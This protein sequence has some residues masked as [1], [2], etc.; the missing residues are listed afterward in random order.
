MKKKIMMMLSVLMILGIT[1]LFP[2][3]VVHADA[4][5]REAAVKWAYEQEGKFLDYDKAWGAQC[6]DLI[7][8]YY[9]YFGKA[10]YAKGNGCKYVSNKLPDGWTRIKNTASFVPEPGD[11]AVWGTELS[12]DGHVA[13]ILSANAHSFVSMDQNWPSGSPCKQVTHSYNK[14]WG[15]IRPDFKKSESNPSYKNFS[16]SKNE[17]KLKDKI[18]FFITPINTTGIGISI[19]KEGVGRVVAAGCNR[20]NGHDIWASDLGVGN[21]SAHITVYNGNKWADTETVWFSVVDPQPSYSNFSVSQSVYNLHDKI[22]FKIDPINAT[23]FG[24]SIDKEGVGRVVAEG[25]NEANGHS[26]WG[27]GLGVG[28]YSA[29]ITVYNDEKWI[30]TNTVYFSVVPPSYSNLE[31]NKQKVG[32]AEDVKFKINTSHAEFMVLKIENEKGEEVYSERCGDSLDSW[33]VKADKLGVGQ[34]KA[35]FLV[36]STNDYYI[37]TEKIPFTV[38]QSPERSKLTCLP[39]NSYSKTIFQW[40]ET[41]YTD[42][43]DLRIDAADYEKGGNIKNVW[44]LRENRCSV[45]LPAGEYAAHVD[46]VNK[47][48]AVGGELIYFTVKEG[49]AGTPVNLGSEVRA[50]I[51]TSSGRPIMNDEKKVKLDRE[52]KENP[53]QIWKF[54]QQSN[55]SYVVYSEMGNGVLTSQNSVGSSV[56]IDQYQNLD[57]QK[58]NLYGNSED[59]YVLKSLGTGYVLGLSGED[60]VFGN[61]VLKYSDDQMFEIEK[62]SEIMIDTP[63]VSVENLNGETD[64]NIKVKWNTCDNATNYDLLLYDADSKELK[65]KISDIEGTSYIL[66]LAVGNYYV[67]IQAKNE[68]TGGKATSEQVEFAVKE[69]I[70]TCNMILEKS[71]FEYDGTE[72]KPQVRVYNTQGNLLQSSE[73]SV[74]YENNLNAGTATVRI[75]GKNMYLG[76]KTINFA[77]NKAS[78][79]LRSSIDGKR[80]PDGKKVNLGITGIGNIS[81]EVEQKDI[82]EVDADGMVTAKTAGNVDVLVTAEGDKNHSQAQITV[83]FIFEHQYDTGVVTK[84]VS[85]EVDG[86]R[87]YTCSGCKASYTEKIKATGHTW[88]EGKITAE[89][90]CTQKGIRTYTCTVCNTTK[91]EEI[92]ATGHQHTELRNAKPA[93]TDTEGYTGDTYCTDC[94]QLI[95]KGTS[96]PKIPVDENAPTITISNSKAMAG[97]EV[98]VNVDILKNTGIAGYSYDINYDQTAMTLKS[99]SAGKLLAGNGQISTNKN[100]VNWYTADNVTGDGTLMQLTFTVNKD[101]EAGNYPVS[102]A[103]HD[104]K[105][106]LVDEKGTFINANYIAGQIEVTKGMTGDLNGDEDITI[107]DVVLLN[108]H[109]LGKETLTNEQQMLADLN[110]DGDITIADVVIL[111]RVVLGKESLLSEAAALSAGTMETETLEAAAQ[112]KTEEMQISVENATVEPGSTVDIP[113]YLRG[114]TGLAGFALTVNIPEGYRLNSIKPG[115]ILSGG[116]FSAYGNNCTWYTGDNISTNGL[117]LTLNVT[118]SGNAKSGQIAVTVKDGKASNL[119]DERGNAV[120]AKFTAGTVS[121]DSRSECDK[122]GHKGGTAT[123]ISKAVCEVCGQEYGE[124]DLNNH[125]GKT[126]IRNKKAA[127]CTEKG[128]SGDEYC[129]GCNAELSKGTEIA[130]LGHNYGDWTVVKPA[131]ATETGLEERV[132]IR[133]NTHKET[134]EIPKEKISLE[135]CSIQL[136]ETAY[137]YDGTEKKPGVTVVYDGT[138]LTEGTDYVLIYKNNTAPG[139]ASVTAMAMDDSSYRGEITA[140]FEIRQALEEA[141]VV[142][143]PNAFSSCANLVNVNIRETVTKIGDQA[144]ADCKNL[145]NVYFY[146]NCPEIGNEIFRNVKAIV[147]YPYNDVTW[148]LEKLQNYGGTITWCP[149]DPETGLPAKRD[150]S[151]CEVSVNM[152]VIT[153]DGTAQT[154]EVTVTDGNTVLQNGKDYTLS[155]ANNVNAGKALVTVTGTGS[156]EGNCQ[157]EFVISQAEATLKFQNTSISK[158]YGNQAFVNEWKDKKTDGKLTWSSSNTRVATVSASGQIKITGVGNTTITVNAAAGTNYKA[159][160][161]AFTVKVAKG[162]NVISTSDINRNFSTKAQT[163][164]IGA[165]VYDKAKISYTS[166]NRLIKVSS[167]GKITIP[168]RFSGKCVITIKTAATTRYESA[169]RKIRLTVKPSATAITKTSNLAGGRAY[170]TWNIN[171]YA[172]GY[173]VQYST[174]SSFRSGVGKVY[175]GRYGTTKTTLSGLKKGKTYYIRIAAYKQSGT[176]KVYSRWSKVRNVKVTR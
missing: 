14:F 81:Y 89:A 121:V 175:I 128:Y 134:R 7:K 157:T 115:T 120:T 15:V 25:C 57:L 118:V 68:Q 38:Y 27:I 130:A 71:V 110:G 127:T 174:D 146:G 50:R 112:A 133:D 58:W 173:L 49:K 176:T 109:V 21:Y 92:P 142:I 117:L 53:N 32:T 76:T 16:I 88:D 119:S 108:R 172:T 87:I 39:G 46:S 107:A 168:A 103:L 139:T 111:N 23:G 143:E 100:V 33:S 136:S 90:T 97:K 153:Y 106:N 102:V 91:T 169:V 84:D 150:L 24:I 69:N 86:E 98:A 149:W 105:K 77:I 41:A 114:N 60:S 129:T 144:F 162:K 167:T 11:I 83:R 13:I 5:T 37:E 36:F 85:C 22:Q 145:R 20:A 1:V 73:Y 12:K 17:Y 48:G 79:I 10:G 113:V 96:I 64:G 99:V 19:D 61:Y 93:T 82:A 95:S 45:W 131:T 101:T 132:C 154:P 51:I 3:R 161:A 29:H 123:C 66:K 155:Y 63:N 43:Y 152:T 75:T 4:G 164:S 166:D 54:I 42:Y 26:L 67:C 165:R 163:V 30:D 18:E 2:Q 74:A 156:Y 94:N 138:V 78:Q 6:V 158:K 171:R 135:A 116:S 9:A 137:V 44:Q 59:G 40:E 35:Y 122:N 126:E 34:Y 147:Y 31:I 160:K 124:K 151:R 72:K 47:D 28:N 62:T 125:I 8:Y 80:V 141:P 170:I 104:G 70:S 55:N 56:Y 148:T 140:D 52:K 65:N 159:G